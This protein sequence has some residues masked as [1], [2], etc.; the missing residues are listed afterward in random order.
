MTHPT[1]FD[2]TVVITATAN[3]GY[4]F[5]QWNDGNTQNPRTIT[6]T[7]DTTF[8]ALFDRNQYRSRNL[9]AHILYGLTSHVK[10]A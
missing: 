2:S 10:R 1:C 9:I 4:H 7:Q 6:L 8:T 3:Y 5:T